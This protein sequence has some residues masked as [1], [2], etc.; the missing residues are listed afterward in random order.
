MDP[1]H[2]KMLMKKYDKDG[3]GKLNKEERNALMNGRKKALEKF[4]GDGDGKLSEDERKKLY[5]HLKEQK[6]E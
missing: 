4:D 6:A 3:D 5:E 1:R 2:R